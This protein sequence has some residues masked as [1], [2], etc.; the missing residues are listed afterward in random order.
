MS[1]TLRHDDSLKVVFVDNNETGATDDVY[2]YAF[3]D[4][5]NLYEPDYVFIP[6]LYAAY[7]YYLKIK[8]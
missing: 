2:M 6:N 3:L 7:Q 4:N 5:I 8:E 1:L